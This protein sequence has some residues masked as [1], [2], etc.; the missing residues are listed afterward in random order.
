MTKQISEQQIDLIVE[1]LIDRVEQANTSFLIGIGKSIKRL[2]DLMPSQA[3]QLIQ[4]LKYGGNY[5]EITKQI[6]KYTDLNI[7]DIDTIFE[8]YAKKDQQFYV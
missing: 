7:K 1:R 5:E 4:V 3:H 2:R 6:A 8:E